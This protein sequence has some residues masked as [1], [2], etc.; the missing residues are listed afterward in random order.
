MVRSDHHTNNA[1][2]NSLGKRTQ[3][4]TRLL[5]AL[6]KGTDTVSLI[7]TA[8][9]SKSFNDM[10]TLKRMVPHGNVVIKKRNFPNVKADY[11]KTSPTRVSNEDFTRASHLD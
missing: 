4:N 2:L 6:K 11:S 8:N 1:F 3:D 9:L 10:P 5:N 7:D